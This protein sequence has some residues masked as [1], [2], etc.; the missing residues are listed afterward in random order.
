[1]APTI[2]N[3]AKDVCGSAS[4]DAYLLGLSG[5]ARAPQT[6]LAERFVGT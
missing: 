6:A 3:A 4:R 2:D 5:V 1:M